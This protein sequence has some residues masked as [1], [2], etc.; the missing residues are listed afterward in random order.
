[1][2]EIYLNN[3]NLLSVAGLKNASS[4]SFMND[5]TVTATL[6]DSASAVVTG[7]TFPLTLAYMAG[8]DGN[9]QAT[10]Q[11]TLNI[12][13][14]TIYTAEITATS[15]SGLVAKWNMELKATKRTA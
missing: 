11:D 9:Y 10:L 6:K 7:Q 8:T 1:M 3:D 14:N 12:T 15:S 5:A 2:K 13:E 4:G